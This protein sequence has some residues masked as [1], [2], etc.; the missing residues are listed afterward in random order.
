MRIRVL[1][2]A[3]LLA[4][5]PAAALAHAHLVRSRPAANA[6]IRQPPRQLWLNF[7]VPIRPTVSGVRLTEPNG[8]RVMLG[9]LT[10]VPHDLESVTAPMPV[11][12]PRGRYLVEWSALDPNAHRT[13]G[14]FVFT[15]AR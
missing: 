8:R 9:P 13:H 6:T 10:W 15:L 1:L 4:L 2:T 14:A 11:G 12:L 3:I 5:Q 7:T